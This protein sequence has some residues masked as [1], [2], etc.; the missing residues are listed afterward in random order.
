MPISCATTAFSRLSLEEALAGVYSLGFSRVDLLAVEGWAHLMPSDLVRSYDATVSRLDAALK[1]N[2]LTLSSINAGFATALEDRSEE[3]VVSRCN[4]TRALVRFMLQH[5]INVAALQPGKHDPGRSFEVALADTAESLREI[6]DIAE[7]TGI[8][9]ALECHSGSIAESLTTALELLQMVPGLKVDYDPSHVV[10]QGI[11]LEDSQPLVDK[12]AIIHLRDAAP[13]E[14]QT[15]FGKGVIDFDWLL[16]Y[17]K[18]RRFRGDLVVEYLDNE[19]QED[20]K[21]DILAMRRK[22]EQYFR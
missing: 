9:F 1:A 15:S 14:M 20:I 21:A 6:T 17:C 13:G 7:G 2:H 5:R 11:E 22:I 18:A 8:T 4:Q 19:T 3:A 10:M 12:A 16:G